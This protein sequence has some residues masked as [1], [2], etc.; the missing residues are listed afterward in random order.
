MSD[1]EFE[2][3]L[4]TVLTEHSK[5]GVS[6]HLRARIATL[7][8][9]GGSRRFRLTGV[10]A[11]VA[12]LAA[13]MSLVG[14]ALLAA[15]LVRPGVITPVQVGSSPSPSETCSDVSSNACDAVRAEVLRFVGNDRQAVSISISTSNI[16]LGDPFNLA[17]AHCPLDPQYLA[18][19]VVQLSNGEWAFVNVFSAPNGQLTSDGRILAAPTGWIP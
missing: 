3:E 18:S 7:P 1:Q 8:D 19:A 16:C 11:G 17:S 15:L 9:R 13:A 10:G 5:G 4:R 12:A 2:N 6:E 14:V